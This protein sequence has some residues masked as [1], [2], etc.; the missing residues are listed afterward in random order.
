MEQFVCT[1]G[2]KSTELLVKRYIELT[3]PP[4]HS[5]ESL[6]T[7]ELRAEIIQLVE[8]LTSALENFKK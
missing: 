5:N 2:T 4:R 1:Y 7:R 6:A 3:I 8:R